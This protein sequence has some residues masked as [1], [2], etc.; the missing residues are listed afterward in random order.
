MRS[1]GAADLPVGHERDAVGHLLGEADLVRH[2]DHR[3]AG[4]GQV[5][6]HVE[7]LA[8][9]LG[10]QRRGGLVEQHQ[11]R[12]HG[13][14]PGDGHPLLLPAGQLTGIGALSPGQSDPIEQLDRLLPGLPGV[15]PLDPGRSLDDV[16]Q[17]GHV[18][19]QVE[20]LN[21]MPMERRCR[22]TWVS[23]SSVSRL[24]SCR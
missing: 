12:L 7:H 18:R 13:Q 19:E 16:L 8:D 9:Q 5:F 3:Q 17:R 24:P 1:S 22:A 23:D 10:I 11:H 6:H 15:E 4:T 14:R 20:P 21:T 2:H